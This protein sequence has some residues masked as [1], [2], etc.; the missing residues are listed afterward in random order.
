VRDEVA[1]MAQVEA[2]NIDYLVTCVGDI[3]HIFSAETEVDH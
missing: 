2:L 3:T 1:A